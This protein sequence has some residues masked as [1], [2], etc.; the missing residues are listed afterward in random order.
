MPLDVQLTMNERN[1]PVKI[2]KLTS[3]GALVDSLTMPLLAH[4][5]FK[6]HF[7]LPPKG[8]MCDLDVK[9]YKTFTNFKGVH[10]AANPGEHLAEVIFKNPPREF[11]TQVVHFN[12][13]LDTLGS[14]KK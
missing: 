12:H 2:K 14:Q 5:E 9:V 4:Q 7:A 11:V 13:Y 1:I 3:S 8:F 10:G 6:M